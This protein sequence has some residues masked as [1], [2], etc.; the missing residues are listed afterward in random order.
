[1]NRILVVFLLSVSVLASAQSD[2]KTN[3][4][5]L[6][7]PHYAVQKPGADL[8]NKF[9]TF[10]SIGM[11]IDFKFRNN[12]ILGVEY[13]WFFGNSVKDEGIF[14]EI[15]G[16]TGLVIDQNGD[17]SV[18]RLNVNGNYATAN[19]GYLLS[20]DKT[21]SFT[22]ILFSAGAGVMQHKIDFLSS[23][24]TIPQL[25][26]EYEDGYDQLTYGLATKEY[27]GYQYSTQKNRYRFRAGIEFNQG[28]TQGRRTWDFNK[29]ESGLI[30][31]F[32]TTTAFKIAIIVPVY[33]K[34][35]ND[36]EFF[37]D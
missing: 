31:R 11:G 9:S 34:K 32:D 35:A 24:V 22:G 19:I 14:S 3:Q 37:I 18:I 30:K 16:P 20:L 33:T 8:A 36:E 27:I 26:D 2:L 23:E 12:I 25:N 29:N 21:E 7:T 10:S 13:D 17:F 28:F 4:G 6:F 5:F 15:S 1:M